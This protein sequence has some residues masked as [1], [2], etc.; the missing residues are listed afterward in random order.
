LD[1][2][3]AAGFAATQRAASQI[4]SGQ[5]DLCLV[6]AG[7]SYIE[8]DTLLWLESQNRLMAR[9]ARSAFAPGEGAACLAL[10]SSEALVRLG[11][12]SLGTLR[13]V[14]LGREP[15]SLATGR[16][17]LGHGLTDAI[18]QALDTLDVRHER[19][20]DIYCDVNGERQRTEE[21]GFAA[22]RTQRALEDASRYITG[23]SAWGDQGAASSGLSIV[24]A[25]QAWQRLYARGN[26]ALAWGSSDAGWCGA[27]LLERPRGGG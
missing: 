14:G 15:N 4:S 27:A 26:L 8:P 11:L 24:L 7:D 18:H 16:N 2:G 22:L 19:V 10:A 12:P 20:T 17:N 9:D 23:V 21:W 1:L 3:P 6:L 13:G 25:V 5:A